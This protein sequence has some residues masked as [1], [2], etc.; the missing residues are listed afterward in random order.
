MQ[1]FLTAKA[2]DDARTV[3]TETP[4]QSTTVTPTQS[5]RGRDVSRGGYYQTN[6]GEIIRDET[7]SEPDDDTTSDVCPA[8]LHPLSC[9]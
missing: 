8:P 4:T 2:Q 5:T 3:T 9:P 6:D 7:E 1:R